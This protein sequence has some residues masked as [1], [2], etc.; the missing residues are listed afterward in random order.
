DNPSLTRTR[1]GAG[2]CPRSDAHADPAILD[3]L[4]LSRRRDESMLKLTETAANRIEE[5]RRDQG[6]PESLGVRVSGAAVT[7]GKMALQV[8]F[9]DGPARSEERRVGKEWRSWGAADDEK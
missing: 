1:A 4:G 3:S 9:S 6:L 7:D 8:A 2:P 5:V